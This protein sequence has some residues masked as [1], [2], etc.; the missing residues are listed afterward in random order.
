MI[1]FVRGALAGRSADGC[2][3]DV[4][5]VGYRLACSAT[6]LKSLPPE[7]EE[8]RLW[9]YVHVRED[10]LQLYGFA[11]EGERRVFEALLGV[12]G[13]GP[14]VALHLCS[15]FA[16]EAFRVA[17]VTGDVDAISSVPGIGKKTAQRILLDLKE[18]LELPDLEVVGRAPDAVA[19]AR[20]ALE[21]LGYSAGE[22]RV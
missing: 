7:D 12:S 3:I 21:N 1:G 6:T 22:V 20:S 9:T 13:V 8:T 19:Q 17:L 11:T 14:K 16:P 5:G 18:K 10:I 2:Y 15:A 4:G